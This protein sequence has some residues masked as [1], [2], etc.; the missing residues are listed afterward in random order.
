MENISNERLSLS[1]K[2]S[3]ITVIV[4]IKTL[5]WI[6]KTQKKSK[7]ALKRGAGRQLDKFLLET[8]IRFDD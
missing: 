7:N 3:L 2:A 8:I 4:T 5:F 1:K 6:S